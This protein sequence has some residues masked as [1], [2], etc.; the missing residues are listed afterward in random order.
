MTLAYAACFYPEEEGYS[1]IVPDFDAATQGDDIKEAI[2][3]TEDLIAGLI[4]TAIEEGKSFPQPS[5]PSND[6]L[7]PEEYGDGGF[8]SVVLVDLSKRVQGTKPGCKKD[9]NNT[10]LGK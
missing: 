10:V 3:M 4:L 6:M 1:V 2:Y 7:E 8:V 5:T 9:F